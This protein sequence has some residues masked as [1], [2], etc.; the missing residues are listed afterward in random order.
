MSAW[1]LIAA[2]FPAAHAPALPGH[3][4]AAPALHQQVPASGTG[5]RLVEPTVRGGPSK[6][7]GM[8]VEREIATGGALGFGMADPKEGRQRAFDTRDDAQPRLPSE[9][10]VKL[11]FSF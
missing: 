1:L 8:F 10:A 5:F 4:L 3:G 2:V 7:P 6:T 9:P 11:H